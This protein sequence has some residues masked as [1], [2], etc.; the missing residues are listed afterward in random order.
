MALL[1]AT[2]M[3][4]FTLPLSI[5]FPAPTHDGVM[6]LAEDGLG[7]WLGEHV[8]WLISGADGMQSDFSTVDVVPEVMELNVD[9][10]GSWAH[11]GDLSDFECTAVVLED[12]AMDGRLGGDHFESLALELLDQLHDWDCSA[13]CGQQTYE[14][15]F[16]RAQ[17]N[18][19]LELR[20]P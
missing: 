5:A 12:T 20:C 2:K 6:V 13:E 1:N 7:Q 9:V 18:F 11:L 8:G 14:L 16:G 3:G 4:I 15:T 17:C 19:R 10:L